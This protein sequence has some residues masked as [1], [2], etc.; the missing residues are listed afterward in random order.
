MY[1]VSSVYIHVPFCR[2]KCNYC[3]FYSTI[4][5]SPEN[6]EKLIIVEFSLY[7]N[8][9]DFSRIKTIYFGGG[10]PSLLA[11]KQIAY[12]IDNLKRESVKEMTLEVNPGTADF[13]K[14]KCFREIGI[15]RLSIGFQSMNNDVLKLL[16]R[17]HNADDNVNIFN[18]ARNAGFDNISI[19]LIVGIPGFSRTT[20][21]TL[22]TIVKLNPEHISAY[23]LSIENGTRFYR[24]TKEGKMKPSEEETIRDEYLTVCDTLDKAGYNHYEISNFAK[25]GKESVHNLI[26]WKGGNYIGLGPSASGFNGKMRYTN[27]ANLKLY[28][29]E[30]LNQKLPVEYSEKLS[31]RNKLNEFVFLNLRL[32]DGLNTEKLKEMFN[33]DIFSEKGEK[34]GDFIEKGLVLREGNVLRLTDEGFILS[35]YVFGKL[36]F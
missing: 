25:K 23:I 11:C 28:G 30:V 29:R 17:I 15:N 20:E 9:Y 33:V 18:R 36:M 2:S 13:E 4:N 35:D 5:L 10:T 27:F 1:K 14:L 16:G 8:N 24:W 31:E 21:E 34:I 32:R 26:Y 7:K 19:D 6:F 12:I 3:A 22:G